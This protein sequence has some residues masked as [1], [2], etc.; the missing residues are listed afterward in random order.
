MRPIEAIDE[1][2]YSSVS[3]NQLVMYSI[4]ILVVGLVV[5]GTVVGSVVV[6]SPMA[7][8]DTGSEPTPSVDSETTTDLEPDTELQQVYE[9]N[10]SAV[11]TLYN[12]N[13]LQNSQGTGFILDSGVIV[14][15]EHTI[16]GNETLYL[17][18]SDG[19]YRKAFVVGA[20]KYTDLSV[21]GVY[22]SHPESATSVEFADA[23][24]YETG[25]Q[26]AVIGSP[27]SFEKSLTTG[28]IS[29]T[30]RSVRAVDNYNIPNMI[31]ID[32]GLNPG[33]S[34]GP[35]LNTEGKVV[36]VAQSTYGEN[37]GFA[38]SSELSQYIVNSIEDNGQHTHPYIGVSTLTLNPFT[39][40]NIEY[41]PGDGLVVT[42]VNEN[43]PADGVFEPA[44][45]EENS[46]TEVNDVIVDIDGEPVSTNKDLS[47]ILVTNYQSGDTVDIGVMNNGEYTV[48][49]ITL[50]E[51][52]EQ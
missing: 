24:E 4:F 21:L 2:K 22:G 15:N 28:V 36:G 48:K 50:S 45:T 29:G 27:K 35:V 40:E 6:L 23:D 11:V 12:Q 32:A 30:H 44:K 46:F 25:D 20:D 39:A 38:V 8:F 7:A 49:T 19:T 26:V 16:T 51:R 47:R 33:N 17:K 41:D 42:T 34:G 13:D 1:D 3:T 37:L 14:T 10:V 5:G 52:P 18:Y 9:E 31:Q 43:T